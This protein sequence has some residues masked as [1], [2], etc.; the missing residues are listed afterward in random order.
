MELLDSSRY[1]TERLRILRG[2][3]WLK[4]IQDSSGILRENS[5]FLSY[6]TSASSRRKTHTLHQQI[7]ILKPSEVTNHIRDR[8]YKY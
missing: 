7:T 3:R 1:A 5:I 6:R 8:I 2:T 4:N